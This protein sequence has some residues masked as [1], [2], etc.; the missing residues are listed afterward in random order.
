MFQKMRCDDDV[1]SELWQVQSC[2]V[3]DNHPGAPRPK[4]SFGGPQHRGRPIH[5]GQRQARPNQVDQRL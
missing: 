5:Q 1:L 4:S 3:A 2:H